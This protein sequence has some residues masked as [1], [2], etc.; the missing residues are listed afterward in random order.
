MVVE[1]AVK[2]NETVKQRN[3]FLISEVIAECD[4][5]A[6]ITE[7]IRARAKTA[8]ASCAE[9]DYSLIDEWQQRV[10]SAGIRLL[11]A[12]FYGVI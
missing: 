11:D 4:A 9:T 2:M 3:E 6:S 12:S 10:H 8:L 1:G 5:I 7:R